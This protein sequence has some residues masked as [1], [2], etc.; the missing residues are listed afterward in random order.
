MTVDNVI[1]VIEVNKKYILHI[2]L[3]LQSWPVRLV[4]SLCP[5]LHVHFN[6]HI[7][8]QNSIVTR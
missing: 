7:L 8:S 1:G 4:E 6:A 3:A 5:Y 2:S